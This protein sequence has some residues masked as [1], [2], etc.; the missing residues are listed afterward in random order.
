[1]IVRADTG[2]QVASGVNDS[3]ANP[4][5]HGEIVCMNDYVARHGNRDWDRM[6]LYTTGEPCPMCMTALVWAG[7]GGVVWGSSI[8]RGIAKYVGEPIGIGAEDVVKATPFR[9]PMVLGGVL[10]EETDR[11][12]RDRRR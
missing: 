4:T 1:M 10:E 11:L 5:W 6:V 7:I 8:H 9:K 3:R 2:E 12:F